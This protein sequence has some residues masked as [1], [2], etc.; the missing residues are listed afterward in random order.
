MQSGGGHPVPVLDRY[1]EAKERSYATI[2]NESLLIDTSSPRLEQLARQLGTSVRHD[3]EQKAAVFVISAA[4]FIL[5]AFAY[6]T[7]DFFTRGYFRGR[8]ALASILIVVAGITA[9]THMI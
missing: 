3:K 5:V 2:W 7:L 9:L 8:L 1:L 4:L 6:L